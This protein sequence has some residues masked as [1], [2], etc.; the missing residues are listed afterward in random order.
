M[1]WKPTVAAIGVIWLASLTMSSNALAQCELGT[2]ILRQ[3]EPQLLLTPH[4]EKDTITILKV[5]KVKRPFAQ[6]HPRVWKVYRG[7]R[8][9]CV[10]LEPVLSATSSAL[11]IMYYLR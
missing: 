6:R 4:G 5:V 3:P 11:S 7:V 1:K 2:G 8:K 9:V 10:T